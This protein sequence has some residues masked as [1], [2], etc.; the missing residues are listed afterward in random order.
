M[1]LDETSATNAGERTTLD[2]LFRRAVSRRPDAIALIDPP[3]RESFTD[4]APRQLSYAEADRLIS[5]IAARLRRI[6][7]ST[8]AVVGVQ[9]PNI[10]E[11]N[12]V[13]LAILR[14][15]MIASPLPLLWRQADCMSALS[16]I[17]AKALITVSRIGQVDYCQLAMQV[18][19]KIFSIRYVCGLGGNLADGVIPLDD[20]AE[21]ENLDPL[22]QFEAGR[23]GNPAAHVAIVTWEVT[24][25][26]LVPVARNH[27]ELLAGGAAL[28]LESRLVQDAA[29]LASTATTSFAG[30]ALTILPWLFTGGTLT[31]HEPF[32]AE[33]LAE[34]LMQS[35]DLAVL[36]APLLPRLLEA[37][38]LS[39][40]TD[41][42][43]IWAVWRSPERLA[44]G[45][46]WP[47]PDIALLDVP[48]FGE[49][50]LFAVRRNPD[51]KP[52]RLPIG[53]VI[54]PR[55]D[56]SAIQVAEIRRSE[57]GSVALGGPMVPRHPFPPAGRRAGAAYLRPAES[58]LVDAG[59]TCRIE[60]G[61]RSLVVT[62][63]PPGIVSVGGYRFVLREL[64]DMISQVQDGATLTALPD[65]LSGHRLAGHAGDRA[66]LREALAQLGVNPLV[67]RAFRDREQPSAA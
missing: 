56:P 14:A 9:C 47:L 7:L 55:G 31:L 30:I 60:L 2:E 61:T 6:G 46:V 3:N 49:T 10:V 27:L 42:K 15:G 11:S 65:G 35:C 41:V 67:V 34:Q 4:G 32:D 28:V 18:A 12:L 52:A 24:S 8:D 1:I 16:R 37:G 39:A 40:R 23:K 13:L 58:G 36:P 59:Y 43:T 44:Q 25:E 45:A 29:I 57:S 19:A 66:A 26:G 54:A 20:L 50:A 22:S 51:G 62:G 17:G 64:Q 5:A 48:V 63:P 53:A 38:I 21:D 33:I